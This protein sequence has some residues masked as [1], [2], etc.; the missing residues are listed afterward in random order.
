MSSTKG[1]RKGENSFSFR[2]KQKSFPPAPP[3][4]KKKTSFGVEYSYVSFMGETGADDAPVSRFRWGEFGY[5]IVVDDLLAMFFLCSQFA[6][7]L[8]IDFD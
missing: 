7:Y 8:F 2:K 4:Q 6:G 3:F 5:I 1:K